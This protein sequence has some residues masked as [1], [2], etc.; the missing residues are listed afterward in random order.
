MSVFG[1]TFA[2]KTTASSFMHRRVSHTFFT[3]DDEALQG[4]IFR[5]MIQKYIL[6]IDKYILYID[7][8]EYF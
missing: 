2:I 6:Y 3:T 1:T 7:K 4:I 5:F 8:N